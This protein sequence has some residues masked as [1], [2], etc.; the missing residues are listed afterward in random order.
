MSSIPELEELQASVF[1]R[2]FPVI[3]KIG[4]KEIKTELQM[5]LLKLGSFLSGIPF[6]EKAGVQL[7]ES[8]MKNNFI[9]LNANT[10][11]L[12][13]NTI[14]NQCYFIGGMMNGE[15]DD[16]S[17]LKCTLSNSSNS[18]LMMIIYFTEVAMDYMDDQRFMFINQKIGQGQNDRRSFIYNEFYKINS[19]VYGVGKAQYSIARINKS[20]ADIK[21]LKIDDI[22]EKKA[23]LEKLTKYLNGLKATKVTLSIALQAIQTK[24]GD[25][26]KER[27][28]KSTTKASL[29]AA[30]LTL[31]SSMTTQQK[32]DK[33]TKEQGENMALLNYWLQGSV[34]YRLITEAEKGSL[35][36]MVKAPEFTTKV[37][38]LFF[39]Q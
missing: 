34:F 38:D 32:L 16:Y 4:D 5:P 39:P 17:S 37:T 13:F 23:Q 15:P 6:Y 18:N 36:G 35:I 19:A 33:M 31:K 2:N 10:F 28:T 27:T 30:I 29:E 12:P 7:T 14:S 26:H 9:K 8:H 25:V 3:I 11:Y 20:D 1:S 24:E 22:N 21:K